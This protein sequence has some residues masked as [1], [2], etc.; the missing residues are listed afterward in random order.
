MQQAHLAT[1]QSDPVLCGC[2]MFFAPLISAS[3]FLKSCSYPG[4]AWA[5]ISGLDVLKINQNE[6]QW[7]VLLRHVV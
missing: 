1:L 2:R 5:K 7:V 3:K 4:Q 6:L